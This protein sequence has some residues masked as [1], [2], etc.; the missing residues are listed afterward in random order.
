MKTLQKM[1]LAYLYFDFY[2]R[3]WLFIKTGAWI[4]KPSNVTI[5]MSPRCNL[6]CKMCRV[7][8]V[9]DEK[10]K[11]YRFQKFRVLLMKLGVG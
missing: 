2:L 7:W 6:K 5:A 10:Q 11:M 1:N 9:F 8:E 3:Q 4:V